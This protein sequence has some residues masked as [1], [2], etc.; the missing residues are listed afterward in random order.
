MKILLTGAC[1]YIGSVLSYHLIKNKIDF[2]G[3]DNLSNSSISSFPK[4]KKLYIGDI[5]DKKLLK[6]I[7]NEYSP[8][9]IIH[10]AASISV[11]ESEKK[12]FFYYKNNFLKSKIFFDYFKNKKIKLFFFSS[13]AAVYE[14]SPNIKNERLKEKA[15]NYYGFTKK[16]FEDYLISSKK[17]R[18]NL[19][20]KIFR[21][22]NVLGSHKNM[23]VG[24]R[25]KKSDHLANKL[26][27]SAIYKKDFTIY[28]N[29]YRTKDGTAIRDFIDVNDIC[30]IIVFFLKNKKNNSIIYN[31]ATEKRYS[32]LEVFKI[33]Q[34]LSKNKINLE[35][36][37]NRSGDAYKL[38]CSNKK[39]K[40]VYK[41]KFTSFTQSLKNHLRFY[42]KTFR[43]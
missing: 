21:F 14:G 24:N 34:G 4:S 30:K 35:F 19:K 29:Q 15:A 41:A 20:I 22:F 32:V 36:G 2:A 39:L 25:S 3:V 31:L 42:A 7:Y 17:Q 6:N 5:S 9:G 12:K 18:Q 16:K 43:K 38:V 26:C 40:R 28:G 11:A 8:D 23:M 10:L 37:P 13:T 27:E 33:F 1:G